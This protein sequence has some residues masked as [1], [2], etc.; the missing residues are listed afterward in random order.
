MRGQF[1]A[2][3]LSK[4]ARR[5]IHQRGLFT[6]GSFDNVSDNVILNNGQG[7]LVIL[8]AYSPSGKKSIDVRAIDM[9]EAAE[10]YYGP[11]MARVKTK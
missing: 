1:S 3:C 4:E 7:S 10:Y 9:W 6:V 5:A 8:R 11:W 2:T